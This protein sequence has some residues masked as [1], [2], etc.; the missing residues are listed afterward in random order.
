MKKL[1]LLACITSMVG[2]STT[3][4][5]MEIKDETVLRGE[6]TYSIGGSFTL[7]DQ[8]GLV[9]DGSYA[10][11]FG[12]YLDVSFKCNDGRT[13]DV[14]MTL[15]GYNKESGTGVGTLSDGSKVRVLLGVATLASA[16]KNAF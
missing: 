7:K 3:P 5:M 11:N 1:V 15:V 13:G 9:C 8:N 10:P 4:V 12:S 6:V 2:C 14:Q 16:Q